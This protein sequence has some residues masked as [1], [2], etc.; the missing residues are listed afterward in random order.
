M[1]NSSYGLGYH[2]GNENGYKNGYLDG[3]NDGL[4]EGIVKGIVVTL[5]TVVATVVPTLIIKGK[6]NNKKAND[7]MIETYKG[8]EIYRR[9]DATIVAAKDNKVI[10]ST[11]MNDIYELIDRDDGSEES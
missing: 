10:T 7:E 8:W 5:L 1:G 4:I 9:N 2:N 11:E 3:K 6:N